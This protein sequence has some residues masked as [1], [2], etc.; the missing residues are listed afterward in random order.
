MNFWVHDS[1][2]KITT[3]P[4]RGGRKKLKKVPDAQFSRFIREKTSGK[5]F[6]FLDRAEKEKK[7]AQVFSFFVPPPGGGV[8]VLTNEL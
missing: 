7:L 8:V 5:F 4:T 2:V 3:P 6:K 1:L